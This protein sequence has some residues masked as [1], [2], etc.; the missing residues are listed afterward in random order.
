MAA[1]PRQGRR[2]LGLQ[3]LYGARV[4]SG[5]SSAARSIFLARRTSLLYRE[6][7]WNIPA[8]N[9]EQASRMVLLSAPAA[10]LPRFGSPDPSRWR[11]QQPRQNSQLRS[12]APMLR[13]RPL[14]SNGLRLGS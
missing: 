4:F 12:T 10:M 5:V 1:I 9:A 13:R 7:Q 14:L 11:P 8:L 2:N 3:R 6:F